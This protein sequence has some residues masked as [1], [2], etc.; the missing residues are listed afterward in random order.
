MSTITIDPTLQSLIP[1]PSAQEYIQ[2][3]TNLLADGCRDPLIIWQETQVLLDEHNRLEIC[4]RHGLDYRLQ[5]ISLPDMDAAKAWM[6]A[7]QLGRRNLTP[8]QMS[9]YRCEQYNLQKQQGKR[10]DL[11]SDHND[12]KSQ[13]TAQRL[14]VQH[15]VS[16]PTIKRDGAYAAAIDLL[17][18]TVG[19]EVR[20][21]LLAREMKLT[22]ADVK[23]LATLL[24]A[25]PETVQA[26][27]DALTG[28]DPVTTL[29]AILS[30]ARCGICH[31]P[32]SDPASVSRG[33]GPICAGHGSPGSPPPG[34]GG[35]APTRPADAL[36]LE[37]EA[38]AEDG[39]P[40]KSHRNRWG[41]VTEPPT[42]TPSQV[43]RREYTGDAEWYTPPEVVA[44]VR[45]VL[46]TIDIDPA[47]CAAAQQVIN[48]TRYYTLEED[49]LR[50][51]WPGTVF[52][53]P[54]YHMP[55][56]ARFCG[57]LLEELDAQQT[58]EAILLTN[59]VTDTDWF[60]RVAPR[61]DALCFTD[62][63]LQFVHA[64]REG[65]RPCQG[66]AVFYFG[67]HAERFCKVFAGL[68][69]LMQVVGAKAAGPQL[70]LAET[71]PAPV[72][73]AEP[74]PLP[75]AVWQVVKQRQPCTNAAVAKALD[76]RPGATHRVLQALVK[77]GKVKRKGHDYRVV[78][79]TSS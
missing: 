6:I 11:T 54:P 7:N 76:M 15:H 24:A 66:Q 9:Y 63:R 39:T 71:P 53:N 25:N 75:T 43:A 32:L 55:E 74:V 21:A 13:N 31:R 14:A 67:P 65:L 2:L 47:S 19:P 49:G 12:T 36:V 64:T 45:Q 20:Q 27:R 69:V 48:A 73:Q 41:S 77:Q 18:E 23:A 57:K 30:T 17:A 35:A 70:P 33:I 26:V 29:K 37:A 42:A 78:D 16:E 52:C 8:E 58:T 46:G 22:Q 50:Q 68:G 56:I 4:E 60:H 62:G 10:T 1:P 34:A 51:R 3:E 72:P 5:E 28:S 38:P 40:V 59:S 79:A 61:A 44:L